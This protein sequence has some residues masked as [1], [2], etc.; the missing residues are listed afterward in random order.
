MCI[1]IY[2]YTHARTYTSSYV[3][4]HV[5][6]YVCMQVINIYIY[7]KYIEYEIAIDICLPERLKESPLN[8]KGW[9]AKA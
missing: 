7:T 3:R 9:H 6:M 8:N 5:C 4:T 1:C 2:E